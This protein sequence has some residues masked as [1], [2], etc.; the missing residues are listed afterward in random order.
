MHIWIIKLLG[1]T[2]ELENT[3]SERC[4]L[5]LF[6]FPNILKLFLAKKKKRKKDGIILE[7]KH[8][9]SRLLKWTAHKFQE[10]SDQ[11]RCYPIFE[12][13]SEYNSSKITNV[14][15]CI[16]WFISVWLYLW[17]KWSLRQV[18]I[19]YLDVMNYA[20]M[21]KSRIYLSS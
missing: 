15:Y 8:K 3:S 21:V 19:I 11:T 12:S 9:S 14:N 20:L 5:L 17:C 2:Y 18:S 7:G 4:F 1:W 6:K 10:T 13:C 16:F